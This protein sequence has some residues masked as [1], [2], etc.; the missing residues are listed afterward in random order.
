MTD[1]KKIIHNPLSYFTIPL[2]TI[3]DIN[4]DE[5]NTVVSFSVCHWIVLYLH[6]N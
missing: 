2:A 4:Y 1:F 5:H 3:L 6:I